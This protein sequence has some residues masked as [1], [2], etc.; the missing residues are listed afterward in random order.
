MSLKEVI[1]KLSC[2]LNF[3]HKVHEKECEVLFF[4][5]N[6]L[7]MVSVAN[8]VAV[9]LLQFLQ[10]INDSLKLTNWSIYLTVFEVGLL[11]YQLS[12]NYEKM[13]EQHRNIAKRCL[14]IKNRLLLY[15][16]NPKPIDKEVSIFIDE[17][18]E[19]YAEAPQTGKLAK[20]LANR[21]KE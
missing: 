17:I 16:S 10:L 21:D 18:N 3:T 13:F 2:N 20:L 12:F 14:S 1:E 6:L 11:S 7:K 9:L 8:I 4:F 15:R 5:N 19:L